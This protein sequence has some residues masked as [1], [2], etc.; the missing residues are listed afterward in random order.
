MK[1]SNR[2]VVPNL[3]DGW[4]VRK[5]GS[6]RASK[7]FDT[8][9]EAITYARERAKQEKTELYIHRKD[10]TIRQKDSYGRDP[11]PPKDGK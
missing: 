9:D 1:K 2:H 5:S 11:H 10:G 7:V 8:Q 3:N 6:D 4:S